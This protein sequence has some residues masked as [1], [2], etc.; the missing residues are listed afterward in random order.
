M[1]VFPWKKSTKGKNA[2]DDAAATAQSVEAESE[3]KA[4]VEVEAETNAPQTSASRRPSLKSGTIE[5]AAT[6]QAAQGPAPNVSVAVP[7]RH[8]SPPVRHGQHVAVPHNATIPPNLGSR[9]QTPRSGQLSPSG[10]SGALSPPS[11]AMPPKML[12]MKGPPPPGMMKMMKGPPPPGAKL[13]KG[14]PPPGMIRMMKGPPPPGAKLIKGPP[15]P[16]MMK[17]MHPSALPPRQSPSPPLRVSPPRPTLPKKSPPATRTP[18]LS[19]SPPLPP[20]SPKQVIPISKQEVEKASTPQ[21][22]DASARRSESPHEGPTVRTKSESPLKTRL[23]APRN[24]ADSD[25][26][27]Q[28]VVESA[29]AGA[30]TPVR[31]ENDGKRPSRSPSKA[32]SLQFHADE[33]AGSELSF[34][35][36]VDEATAPQKSQ[37]SRRNSGAPSRVGDC[38]LNNGADRMNG[39]SKAGVNVVEQTGSGHVQAP[40]VA[41]STTSSAER[42]RETPKGQRLKKELID[43]EESTSISPLALEN[44]EKRPG[45]DVAVNSPKD[46]GGEGDE[47]CMMAPVSESKLT[48]SVRNRIAEQFLSLLCPQQFYGKVVKLHRIRLVKAGHEPAPGIKEHNTIYVATKGVLPNQFFYPQMRLYE[49]DGVPVSSHDTPGHLDTPIVL[50]EAAPGN[51]LFAGTELEAKHILDG[52]ASATSCFVLEKSAIVFRDPMKYVLPIAMLTVRWIPYAVV[53]SEPQCPV[54]HKELQLFDRYTK[55]LLCALCVS[56]SGAHVSHLVV[57]PDVL[58]GDSRRRIMEALSEKLQQGRQNAAHWV[59][60]HQRIVSVVKHKKDA[61]N[62]QF[63]L[64]LAAVNSKREEFLEHCDAAFGFAL[65]GVAKE[66]LMA[67]EKVRLLKSA[68]DHLLTESTKPLYSMQIATVANALHASEEFPRPF[69]MDSLKIPA[70]S[71]ELTPNLEGVMTELQLVSPMTPNPNAQRPHSPFGLLSREEQQQWRQEEEER[72]HLSRKRT[73]LKHSSPIRRVRLG[74]GSRES[75]GRVG[76][77]PPRPA[78]PSRSPRRRSMPLVPRYEEL[79]GI[80]DEGE[81]L[82][83]SQQHSQ[84][85]AVPGCRG[86]CIF[87]VPIHELLAND[88]DMKNHRARPKFLQWVL[89]V[90]DPGDWV[91]VG[92]GVGGS[93]EAWAV[94]RTPDLS[95]LWVVTCGDSRHTFTLR[96]TVNPSVGHA[97]LS[98]HDGKGKQLDDGRIPQWNATRSCYPQVTFGGRI[99]EVHLIDGPHMMS[100]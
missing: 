51:M 100:K 98:I 92:V 90:E 34:V 17:M 56:K 60:Q 41:S 37:T 47:E 22:V 95:H 93:L 14:P 71:R 1:P 39:T 99:G 66:I 26:E 58:S 75:S 54:H 3:T 72:S 45:A 85:V 38:S 53:Q 68:I 33:S 48:P 10:Q 15:P 21:H 44:T 2:A 5:S 94:S 82:P 52:N 81:V 74:H 59:N 91:G 43:S 70:L 9:P 64:L 6:Q 76:G 50:Y 18:P 61:V 25:S 79:R 65:G 7:P 40:R 88:D 87:D 73:P 86:T 69:S 46:T 29:S 24:D 11:T 32:S 77:T 62:Q 67:D 89:R 63:D 80:P 16:G 96:V 78:G 19:S 23:D 13:V 27:L 57:I 55:E 4:E 83:R 20:V 8:G 84:W 49:A 36:Q 30:A 12:P 31:M 35:L 28:F 42:R 97:K